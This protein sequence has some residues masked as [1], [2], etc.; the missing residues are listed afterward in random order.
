MIK[1]IELVLMVK[2]GLGLEESKDIFLALKG[3]TTLTDVH[4]PHQCEE[5]AQVCRYI[6]NIALYADKLIYYWRAVKQVL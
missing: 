6:T 3:F 1:Q 4:G 2:E 5:L